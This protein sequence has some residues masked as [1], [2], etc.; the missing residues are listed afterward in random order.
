MVYKKFPLSF[1]DGAFFSFLKKIIFGYAHSMN[2]TFKPE[3]K[4]YCLGIGGIGLSSVAQWMKELGCVV[5]GSDRGVSEVTKMLEAKGV[6]VKIE[7][8][9]RSVPD[10][11]E[12]VVYSDALPYEHPARVFARE[13]G[14]REINYAKCLGLLTE[15]YRCIAVAGSHGKSTTTA[16]IAHILTEAGLDPTV[17]VGTKVPTLGNVNFRFGKSD[18]VVVEADEFRS[19]FLELSPAVAIINNVDHDHVD[20]FPTIES[21]VDA[22]NKFVGKIKQG[23]ELILRESDKYSAGF[24]ELRNDVK[25]STFDLATGGIRVEPLSGSTLIVDFQKYDNGRQYFS[26]TRDGVSLGEFNVAFPGEHMLLDAVAGISAVIPFID[27]VEKIR[28]AMATFRGTWRRFELLGKYK[29]ATVISDYAHHPTELR[30]LLSGARQAYPNKKITIVFQPHQSSRT[31]AFGAD[32]IDALSLADEVLLVD[33][34]SV[35]GRDNPKDFVSD[36]DWVEVLKQR[37]KEA[38]FAEDL[39]V[40][41]KMLRE[42]EPTDEVLLFVGAG[43]I[44]QLARKLI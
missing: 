2:Q 28:S 31:Q 24:M 27:N 1:D 20:V 19:H 11:T 33:V 15:S 41:E 42:T 7:E 10:D 36:R 17:V 4:V 22:F 34:F 13:K 23:G 6:T 25:I 35:A 43:S 38:Y 40:A 16:L 5:T 26:V 8:M 44:D 29:S 21:Y 12:I 14:I 32:F 30:A 18:I 37:G 9:A 39:I 3:T